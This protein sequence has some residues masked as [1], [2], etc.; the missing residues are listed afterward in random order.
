MSTSRGGQ[1]YGADS[2]ISLL[3]EMRLAGDGKFDVEWDSTWEG[4]GMG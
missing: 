4:M 2:A 3:S 1:W